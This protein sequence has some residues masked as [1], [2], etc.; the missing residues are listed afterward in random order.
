[1]TPAALARRAFLLSSAAA[2]SGC[3]ALS[4]LSG[5]TAELDVYELR[6]PAGGPVAARPLDRHL[7]VEVPTTA[8]ALDTDRIMIRPNALQA[9][10]LPDARWGE[11]V[12]V[13]VQTLMLRSFENTQG[14]RYVGR[15]PVGPGGDY[16]LITEISDFQAEVAGEG[17]SIRLRLTARLVREADARIV[18]SR[19]F[20]PGA[21]AAGT[22]TIVVV[23][24][25]DRA[26]AGL[27]RDVTGWVMASLGVRLGNA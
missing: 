7:I 19:T 12:P 5:A 15:R 16:A 17:A 18:A 3:S 4:A 1:M 11:P 27:M 24:A 22:D 20:S 13:M 8:G 10:Y 14:L 21:E 23:E 9:Q 25:F 26:V 2:L 6:A